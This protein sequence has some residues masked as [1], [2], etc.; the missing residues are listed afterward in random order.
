MN[1]YFSNIFLCL[2]CSFFENANFRKNLQIEK[3]LPFLGF[4]I[5]N[6]D[7]TFLSN[8]PEK[9]SI[10]VTSLIL[11]QKKLISTPYKN[12]TKIIKTF[13]PKKILKLKIE[14]KSDFILRDFFFN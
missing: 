10:D 12:Q 4:M 1:P 13:Y 9:N 6:I 11:T 3:N 7:T 8:S 2:I 5:Y 14:T